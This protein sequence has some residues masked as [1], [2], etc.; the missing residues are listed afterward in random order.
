MSAAAFAL[1]VVAL[2]TGAGI[3]QLILALLRRRAELRKIDADTD[4]VALNSANIYIGTLQAGEAVL[5]GE[6]SALKTELR[7]MKEDR[8]NEKLEW[9]KERE[10]LRMEWDTER[11]ANTDALEASTREV[12]RFRLQ[13]I[14][15]RSDLAGA[16]EE[17]RD[18]KDRVAANGGR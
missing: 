5:R 8:A 16:V 14:Q 9:V 2:V 7:V 4:S 13:L 12:A 6:V 15:V 10:K 3:I 11:T 17:I 18:L 1:Q